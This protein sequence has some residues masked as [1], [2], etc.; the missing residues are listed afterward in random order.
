MTIDGINN[1]NKTQSLSRLNKSTRLENNVAADSVQFSSEAKRNA[2][3]AKYI[4]I[5]KNSPDIRLDKVEAAKINLASYMKDSRID[6][7]VLDKMIDRLMD[8]V[9]S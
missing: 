7:K 4:E 5:V 6:P 9:L 3:T 1:I 8:V 2:E